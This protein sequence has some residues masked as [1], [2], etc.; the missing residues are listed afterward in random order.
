MRQLIEIEPKWLLEVAPHFY[1]PKEIED[2]SSK[3][4]EESKC[5]MW[6]SVFPLTLFC[7]T[8]AENAGLRR[9]GSGEVNRTKR[10]EMKKR[11]ERE[12]RQKEGSLTFY[13]YFQS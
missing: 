5:R 6:S 1:K 2:A 7:L 9:R 10:N 11:R 12:K 4:V 13:L 8:D 3:K